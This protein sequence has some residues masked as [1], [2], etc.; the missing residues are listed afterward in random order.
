MGK[1]AQTNEDAE[2]ADWLD[3]AGEDESMDEA[4]VDEE[5]LADARNAP[6]SSAA[7]TKPSLVEP[8]ADTEEREADSEPDAGPAAAPNQPSRAEAKRWQFGT[9]IV[10]ESS[11][12]LR[13]QLREYFTEHGGRVFDVRRLADLLEPGEGVGAWRLA[14]SIRQ[15]Q[16]DVLITNAGLL[17]TSARTFIRWMRADPQAAQLRLAVMGETNKL[18]WLRLRDR[19]L[20]LPYPPRYEDLPKLLGAS[21]ADAAGE[22]S[23]EVEESVTGTL[24][25]ILRLVIGD[26]A[27]QATAHSVALGCILGPKSN[28][29]A[30][31]QRGEVAGFLS[32]RL[33]AKAI[34]LSVGQRSLLASIEGHTVEALAK[35]FSD[36]A[37]H[38]W[39]PIPTRSAESVIS[40]GAADLDGSETPEAVLTT[41]RA[42]LS[43][44]WLSLRLSE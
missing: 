25:D 24:T 43:E 34:C 19:D 37:P 1:P 29:L 35:A 33:A 31:Q 30:R 41:L 26:A 32:Q 22:L 15:A 9:L 16:P 39:L 3:E 6:S 28:R 17:R 21:P 5:A 14:R 18:P 27:G 2:L 36:W 20:A 40:W 8:E 12:A 7:E 10:L 23:V 44:P 38:D 11:P 42:G 13:R 4:G